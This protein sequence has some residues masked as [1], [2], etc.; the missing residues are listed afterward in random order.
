[1][2]RCD[3]PFVGFFADYEYALK[4]CE[5]TPELFQAFQEAVWGYYSVNKRSFVWRETVDPYGIVVSEVMLQQTQTHRVVEK[6]LNFIAHF[7]TFRSLASASGQ[8]VLA[9]WVGLG[10]NR[11]ALALHGIAQR[12]MHEY[13]G[14]LPDDPLVLQTFKGLGPATASSIVAFAFNKPTV[15]IETNIRSVY[16]HVFFADQLGVADKLLVPL[17]EQTVDQVR[18]REWY[19]ALMDCGVLLKKLYGNPN[20]KSKHYSHQS[21]F[22]G[23]NS[24]VRGF[25]IRHLTRHK[26]LEKNK[27][28]ELFSNKINEL[29]SIIE[30][31]IKDG[32]IIEC[33]GIIKPV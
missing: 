17:V 2:I 11:R 24:Q 15:F 22:K 9:Q 13:G 3:D 33:N 25:I 5:Y 21:A 23:S 12:I 28:N 14:I 8:A 26:C 7:P 31:L 29:P 18:A 10:Y 30:G 27:L 16:L 32:F 19:Y 4:H 1:M 20:K 6:Y